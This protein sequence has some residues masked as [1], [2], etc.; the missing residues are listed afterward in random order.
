MKTKCF[1]KLLPADGR[2]DPLVAT[3]NNGMDPMYTSQSSCWIFLRNQENT[4]GKA[5]LYLL[6]FLYFPMKH[7]LMATVGQK[8]VSKM[9]F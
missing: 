9:D 5:S 1:Q 2:R 4:L 8:E 3:E 6:Y 7:P